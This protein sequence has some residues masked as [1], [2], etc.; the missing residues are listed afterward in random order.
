VPE[1]K[2]SNGEKNLKRNIS[3]KYTDNIQSIIS[4]LVFWRWHAFIQ[5]CDVTLCSHCTQ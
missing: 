5:C 3:E 2:K 4:P 1:K